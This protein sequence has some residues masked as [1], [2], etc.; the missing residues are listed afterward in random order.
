MERPEDFERLAFDHIVM[1]LQSQR[2]DIVNI[3]N[4]ASIS[5]AITGLIATFFAAAIGPERLLQ[6]IHGD[7][8]F[9]FS[10]QALLLL[11]VF[12]ASIA[13][14]AMA[15][16]HTYDFTFSFNTEKM[17]RYGKTYGTKRLFEQYVEDGEWFFEDNERNIAIAQSQLFFATVFG[18]IQV[19]PWILLI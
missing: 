5:A 1:K 4:R 3:R 9:G 18:W 17:L 10:L 12:S 14:S 16:V 13:C 2:E 11:F 8:L 7:A 19:L 6:T 15:L